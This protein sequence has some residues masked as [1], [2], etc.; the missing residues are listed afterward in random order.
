[1]NLIFA[2]GFFAA[3]ISTN[4]PVWSLSV[5]VFFYAVAPLIARLSTAVVAIIA[6]ASFSLF[7][8][9]SNYELSFYS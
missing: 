8:I 7:A 1:M 2:Q 5:E 6:G 9:S 3:P 4:G